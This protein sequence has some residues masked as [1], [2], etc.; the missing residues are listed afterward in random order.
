VKN[1]LKLVLAINERYPCEQTK[2]E[3]CRGKVTEVVKKKEGNQ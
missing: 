3:A 2:S 1:L